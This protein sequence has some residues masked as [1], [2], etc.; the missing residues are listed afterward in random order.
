[1][2]ARPRISFIQSQTPLHEVILPN[3]GR[4]LVKREDMC[5]VHSFKWRGAANRIAAMVE[6]GRRGPITTVSAGNHAQGVA[7]AAKS[8]DLH[9]TIFMPRS[10]PDV[11]IS[12]V[13]R[14]GGK[15]VTVRLEGDSY[16]Q[17]SVRM[18]KYAEENGA[19]IIHA[20]DDPLVIAGQATIGDELA[21]QTRREDVPRRVFIAIG[22]G[23]LAA[24]IAS[25]LSRHW[26][27][28]EII[29]V[30]GVD[31]ASM[32]EAI[33]FGA[34]VSIEPVDS[35]SDGTAVGRAGSFTLPICQQLLS[36]IETVTNDEICGAIECLWEGLRAIPEPSGAMAMAAILRD[37][38]P[39]DGPPDMT[40]MCG[41]NLDFMTIPRI[42]ARSHIGLHVRRHYRFTISEQVGGLA[43][44]SG[45]SAAITTSLMCNLASSAR[46]RPIPLS[47]LSPP[48]TALTSS[49]NESNRSQMIPISRSRTFRQI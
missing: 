7:L 4:V 42:A 16:D 46:P 18:H 14:L 23:G 35:F 45:R 28:T 25:V 19:E 37:P 34:P 41:A 36:R 20:Y 13:Q 11:K 12:A 27:N 22:G 6:A 15:H 21:M 39:A 32:R 3:G 2:L 48:A 49:I 43:A 44:Y 26:P 29:G 1:M 30:E 5:E 17:S 8:F 24:G 33:K 10:S 40:I 9:A 31:Q 38:P 47:A